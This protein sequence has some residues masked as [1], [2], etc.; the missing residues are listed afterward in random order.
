MWWEAEQFV[1]RLKE[2]PITLTCLPDE[3]WAGHIHQSEVRVNWAFS[4]VS[5][6]TCRLNSLS[7]L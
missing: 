4:A 2:S 6:L 3:N 7:L 1:R 5:A